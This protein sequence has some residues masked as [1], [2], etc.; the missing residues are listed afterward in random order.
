MN[1]GVQTPLIKIQQ[2]Q[3]PLNYKVY[4]MYQNY[5]W[6]ILWKPNLTGSLQLC[7]ITENNIIVVSEII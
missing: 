3:L 1:M 4:T 5:E 7:V 2:G 6:N